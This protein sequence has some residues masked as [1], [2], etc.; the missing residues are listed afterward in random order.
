GLIVK[1]HP[2]WRALALAGLATD[3]APDIVDAGL[4]HVDELAG[5]VR[6]RAS[7]ALLLGGR[8]GA[9][10]H[11]SGVVGI[12]AEDEVADQ[13][14]DRPAGAQASDRHPAHAAAV[15]D[16]AGL[17]AALPAHQRLLNLFA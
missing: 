14:Q 13:R 2:G 12:D 6:G 8:A 5:L 16:V 7:L 17:P 11:R 4:D 1:P 15:L 9:G 10:D 3:P